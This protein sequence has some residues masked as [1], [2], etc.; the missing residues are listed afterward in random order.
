[1]YPPFVRL[2]RMTFLALGLALALWAQGANADQGITIEPIADVRMEPGATVDVSLSASDTEGQPLMFGLNF[3]PPFAT[4]T[5]TGPTSG[6]VHITTVPSDGGTWVIEV[7]ALDES[8]G[9]VDFEHFTLTLEPAIG[10]PLAYPGG[11]YLGGTGLPVRFDASSSL[12]PD[13]DVLTYL[14]DFGDGLTGVGTSPLHTYPV[15]GNYPVHLL[16]TDPSGLSGSGHTYALIGQS[17]PM[18]AFMTP[19]AEI[20][21]SPE[22]AECIYLEA[23]RS[24]DLLDDIRADDITMSYG[25]EVAWAVVGKT[26]ILGDAD[27][28]GV[29]DV[30]VCFQKSDLRRLFADLPEGWSGVTVIVSAGLI[31]PGRLA[32]NLDLSV[33]KSSHPATAQISPN[34]FSGTGV[35]RFSTRNPGLVRI[36][37]YDVQGRR[38]TSAIEHWVP[39]GSHE[40]PVTALRADGTPLARGVYFFRL[41]SADGEASGRLVVAR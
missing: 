8:L 14:W 7:W 10:A 32:T 2:P 39:P 30:K 35:L 20:R 41:R 34:P 6:V 40:V 4:V 21:L 12:D 26:L 24:L 25:S 9:R 33:L 22:N 3:G 31:H 23:F 18:D 5:T 36:E 15:N 37:I 19:K 17:F 11:P 38:A 16:V 28:D 29:R 13:S 1:M 27:H